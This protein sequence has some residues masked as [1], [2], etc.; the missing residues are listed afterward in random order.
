MIVTDEWTK[1]IAEAAVPEEIDLAPSIARAFFSGEKERKQLFQREK[2]NVQGAFGVAEILL[3]LPLI[4]QA[5]VSSATVLST[6]ISS[7]G[8]NSF[9]TA[10]NTTFSFRDFGKRRQKVASLPD[11]PFLPL[12]TVLLTVSSELHTMGLSEEESDLITFRVLKKLLE[13]PAGASHF[14]QKIAE[15]T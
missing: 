5:L 10:L 1:K 2:K 9:L 3:I 12:K 7:T 8:L 15:A 6:F 4:L 13:D 11:N 14:I